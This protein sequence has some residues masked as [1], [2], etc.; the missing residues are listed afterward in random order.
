MRLRRVCASSVRRSGETWRLRRTLPLIE[1]VSAHH[2][3]NATRQPKFT[4]FE[5]P[6][7]R[8]ARAAG[9]TIGRSGEAQ[10]ARLQ[11]IEHKSARTAW[12]SRFAPVAQ[13]IEQRFPKPRAQVRFLSGAS[14]RVKSSA[15]AARGP[16]S[17]QVSTGPL[18]FTSTSPSGS[19]TKSS[20]SSSHVERVIWISSADPCDSILLAM[21]TVS[22]QRS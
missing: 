5:L 11:W 2:V 10:I 21:F 19:A 9:L 6:S 13:W 18:P 3:M 16:T 8:S 20:R 7:S 12:L 14:N 4:A 17:R 1:A 22:P 15:Y